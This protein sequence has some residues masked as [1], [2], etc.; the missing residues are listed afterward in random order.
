MSGYVYS[1]ARLE[2][3]RQGRPSGGTAIGTKSGGDV[4]PEGHARQPVAEPFVEQAKSSGTAQVSLSG[5]D[6]LRAILRIRAFRRIWAVLGLSS[7]GDWLGLLATSTFAAQQV[8]GSAAKGLAFSSVIAVRLLPALVLGPIAG[9]IA[10]RFDRRHTMVAC[11]IVRFLL[12][13]S[14]PTVGL[15]SANPAVVVGWA[16]VATFVIE[17]VGMVWAPAKEAAV[18]NLLPRARLERAN[19]LTLATTYGVTPVLAALALAGVTTVVSAV[20]HPSA[21]SVAT[22]TNVALYFNALT[23]LA[24]AVVVLFGI[25][26]ISGRPAGGAGAR[27]TRGQ[28]PSLLGEFVQ[29]W[30]YVGRTPLVRGLVLGILGAFAGGGV[31]VGTA[32]FYA[33]SLNG[34]DSTFYLL[35][36]VLFIGLGAG[37]VLGPRLIG[38]LSRR[39]WFGLS[40]VLAAVSVIML[41]VAWHLTLATVGTFGVGV[42]AGM[43]FLSGTTLLGGEVGDDVRGR[44][45]A[46]VQT[47]TRVVL[48]LAISLSG[49]LVGFGGS[50]VFDVAGLGVQVSSTRLLLLAAGAFGMVT[51]V[52]AL[53][54]MDDKPGVP[55]LPDLISSLRGRPLG[56]PEHTSGGLFVVYEGGEGAGKSTQVQLLADALRAQGREVV[57]TR[58]PGATDIGLRIRRLLLESGSAAGGPGGGMEAV[59]LAPRAEA[60]LYAADRAHH[61]ATV[62]RPALRRGAV[63]VSDR[64]VDSS[65][66]YQGA[67]RTLPVDEVSWLS[68]W[69]T[70]GLKPDLVVLLDVEPAVG[71]AR[72]DSRGHGADRLESESL[73]FHERVRYAFLD[74]ASADPGRYLVLDARQPVAEL[75][76]AAVERVLALLPPAPVEPG[77]PAGR[78]DVV[79]PA[80]AAPAGPAPADL[81]SMMDVE[82]ERRS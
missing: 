38:A 67:G 44:V 51:G 21:Q 27:T 29:G 65:L 58:E 26:E 28:R 13:A 72:A 25:R 19:Q 78:P 71:L 41:A 1:P 33:R 2:L 80:S 14:I 56:V 50:R 54:Q 30:T 16:A 42:G 3:S 76:S 20:L 64:Y 11:D 74:L 36:A 55:I 68:R 81:E 35:F 6:E 7:L 22:P 43:A 49:V 17:A 31:V 10:D 32:Q 9:V 12:F 77:P 37:I 45:F 52:T 15:L 62:V 69:A 24:T 60:L 48:M 75:T 73:S 82:L 47:S 23:F 66:A 39:R 46:F 5:F 59:T 4:S 53:Q 18:P 40:I 63:V 61:V 57:V 8:S 70:G 79:G 34:G